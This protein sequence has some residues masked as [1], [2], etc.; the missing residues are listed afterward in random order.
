VVDF[1][2]AGLSIIDCMNR[3]LEFPTQGS[4][5]ARGFTLIEILVTLSVAAILMGMAVPAFNSFVLNDRDV[6]QINSLVGSLNYARSE[7]IKRASANGIIVCPSA[8]GTTCSGTAW[9]GGW[10]VLDLN[11]GGLVLQTVPALNGSNTLTAVGAATGITFL[12]SGL[13]TAALTIRVCDTR[14]ANFARDVEVNVTGRVAA[15][16]TPGQAVSGAALVCP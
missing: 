5:A 12:T 4:I 13:V 3:H 6:G 14:G 16:Q 8:N 7:A 1:A 10:I 9:A 15:S 2:Q 11:P